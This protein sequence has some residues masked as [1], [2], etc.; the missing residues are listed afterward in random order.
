MAPG[1]VVSKVALP[2]KTPMGIA[3][4]GDGMWLCDLS[5]SSICKIDIATG[6]ITERLDAPGISPSGLAW[7]G[8]KL[9]VLD[10]S[11]KILY[12]LVPSEKKTVKAIELESGS[13]Q[14]LGWDGKALWI[15]DARSGKIEKIDTADGTTITSINS[16]TSGSSKRT[17]EIG[18]AFSGSKAWVSDR[19]TDTLYELDM[20]GG[21]VVNRFA[22]PGP[23]P[24]GLAWDG[25]NLWCADY[26]QRVLYK[27]NTLCGSSYV[28][29]S[30]KKELVSYGEKWRNL[31]TG[32]VRTLDVYIAVPTDLPSQRLLKPPAF[33]P[34]P[35]EFILDKW[36][37][38]LA[39]FR[40]ENVKPG[41]EVSAVMDVEVEVARVRWHLDP[42]VAGALSDIPP[43]FDRAYLGD[44]TKLDISSPVIQK[45]VK[46]AVGDEKNCYWIARKICKYIQEKMFYEM[47]GGW[48]TAPAVLQRGSGSCSEY[49]FVMLAMC[50]AAGLPG[51]YQGSVVIRGDDASR[52]DVF[53]RWVEVYLPNYGWVPVDPS[54][55]DSPVPEDQAKYFGELDNRF[56]ITTVGGGSSEYLGWDYNSSS[57]WTAE[58]PVKLVSRKLGDWTPIGKEYE[59]KALEQVGGITCKP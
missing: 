32:T 46:E 35:Q 16:P 5:T 44:D 30:P 56:L 57:Q 58:G 36:K 41:E 6:K 38:N 22:S 55:G 47:K 42:E 27:L 31:G 12:A 33:E 26:E 1:E 48:N 18:M 51:R 20:R 50:R 45:A 24:T 37:Q 54:G 10:S 11:D 4:D 43:D 49:T 39:H 21:D 17:E 3:W 15:V 59:K 40:F 14:G 34:K 2:L 9:W 29:S 28:T 8:S 19:V 7:D 53:H 52:D 23:Y 13:P 25:A